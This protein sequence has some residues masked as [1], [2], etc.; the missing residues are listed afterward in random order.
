MDFYINDI[1]HDTEKFSVWY[2]SK[3]E[4]DRGIKLDYLKDRTPHAIYHQEERLAIAL[5]DLTFSS[6]N[7]VSS[8]ITR[9]LNMGHPPLFL[10][11]KG[12]ELSYKITDDGKTIYLGEA[13]TGLSPNIYGIHSVHATT[14]DDIITYLSETHPHLSIPLVRTASV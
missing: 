7:I 14:L 6:Q 10:K 1:P 5:G 2:P 13:R 9:F 11:P 4:D 3:Q 12:I 8:G